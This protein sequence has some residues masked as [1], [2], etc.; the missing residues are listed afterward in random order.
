MVAPFAS[1]ASHLG[2]R[3]VERF[4]RWLDQAG[5]V[6]EVVCA[7]GSVNGAF[8]AIP[9]GDPL[10]ML[11]NSARRQVADVVQ[12]RG[13]TGLGRRLLVPDPSVVWAAKAALSPLV[14]RAAKSASLIITTGPPESPHIAG[15]MLSRRTGT[16]HLVD[17]RDG[18]IDEPLKSELE[19]NGLR[20]AAEVALEHF[21]LR[22]AAI[23]TLSSDGWR[24]ALERRHPDLSARLRVLTN[25]IPSGVVCGTSAPAPGRRPKLLYI[26]RL[27][28]SRH[29]QCAEPLLELLE[30]EAASRPGPFEVQF[31]GGFLPSELNA[32]EKFSDRVSSLDW[33]VRIEPPIS[34][35]KA[36][37]EIAAADGLLLLCNSKNAI[38]SKLFDYL[39]SR[40]PILC[41]AV[42]R[43]AAWN[44]C[45]GV[46]QA[47]LVDISNPR[48]K[49]GFCN[50]VRSPVNGLV[51]ETLTEGSVA[52][53]FLKL[54]AE[55]VH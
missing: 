1:D 54:I 42:M 34:Y 48:S 43:G 45:S 41:L 24:A 2:T 5:I 19:S 51:P 49:V 46:P 28:G 52:A 35:V 12:R 37:Q 16:P 31:R 11:K 53:E 20:R 29:S 18:W 30:H 7:G 17:Y 36:L 50:A 55:I 44:I 21:V 47:W 4:C 15:A 13:G 10:Q 6:T 9:V 39:G 38:P 40:R 14:L 25:P 3:R 22:S 8:R 26:G 27:E 33:C 32:I 23:V